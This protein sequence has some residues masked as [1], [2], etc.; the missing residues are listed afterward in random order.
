MGADTGREPTDEMIL[1]WW[2]RMHGEQAEAVT[3][4]MTQAYMRQAA[5]LSQLDAHLARLLTA[6][7]WAEI[8]ERLPPTAPPLRRP[9]S[10]NDAP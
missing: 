9:A 3:P 7:E 5:R 4:E 2:K 10:D 6:S 1:A 8:A